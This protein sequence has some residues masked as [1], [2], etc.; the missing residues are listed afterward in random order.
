MPSPEKGTTLPLSFPLYLIGT[1]R[2]ALIPPSAIEASAVAWNAQYTIFPD[3]GHDIMLDTGCQEVA[4]HIVQWIN[5]S[6]S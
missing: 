6:V 5:N 4:E 1:E 3:R 2:D